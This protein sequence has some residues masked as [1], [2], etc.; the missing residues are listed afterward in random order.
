LISEGLEEGLARESAIETKPVLGQHKE[1]I[2]I[3]V[4]AYEVSISPV[5]FSSMN[6]EQ[7]F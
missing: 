3:E 5:G 6:E 4:I 2:F 7:R 1:R